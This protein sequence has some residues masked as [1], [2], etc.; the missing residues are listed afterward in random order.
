MER[1][2]FKKSREHFDTG[3]HPSHVTFDDG[4]DQRRNLP[5]SH[6]VEARWD[7][8]ELDT[9]KVEIGDW[10]IIIIGHN[11]APLF[12]AL[13]EQ[14][15]TRLRAQPE[16]AADRERELDTFATK[17]RFMKSPSPPRLG[18]SELPFGLK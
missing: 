2:T 17:I 12:L 18:Q 16:I 10:L 4:K 13:E 3:S 8:A 6:Y 5:W 11:L 1:P 15:L 14:S 7:Y 9:L